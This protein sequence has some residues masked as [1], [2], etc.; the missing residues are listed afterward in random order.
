MANIKNLSAPDE[1]PYRVE[2]APYLDPPPTISRRALIGHAIAV[3]VYGVLA[4]LLVDHGAPLGKDILGL[5]SDPLLFIWCL[6]WW[7]HAVLQHLDPLHVRLLWQPGGI[8]LAWITSIPFLALLAAPVTLSFGPLVSYNLLAI[9]AP[10][11]A[12]CSAYLLCFYVSRRPVAAFCGGLVFGF[13]SYEMAESLE[14]LNLA[15]SALVPLLLLVV[16]CRLN[17]RLQRGSAA[18]LFALLLAGQFYISI[19]VAATSLFFGAL[20]WALASRLCPERRF[21]LQ[22]LVPDGIL[23]GAFAVPLLL[24][25]LWDMAFRPR[26]VLV[27][28]GWSIVTSTHL[29]NLLVTTPADVF[30]LPGF[31][32]GASGLLGL[33]PQ[34]DFSTGLPFLVLIILFLR[35][36][37]RTPRGKFL[38]IALLG[39][40]VASLGPQ[41][42]LGEKFTGVPMPWLVMSYVPLLNAALP[43]RFALYASLALALIL[44][45]WAGKSRWR[46]FLVGFA[47]LVTLAPLHPV[48]PAPISSFF[49]PG[50]VQAAL[51]PNARV[52]ILPAANKN[53]PGLWQVS[54]FLQAENKFGFVQ[55][56][57]YLGIPPK[58]MQRYA[59]IRELAFGLPAPHFAADVAILSAATHTQFILAGPDTPPALVEQLNTLP[60]PHRRVDDTLVYSVQN[61]AP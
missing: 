59:A 60:W 6:A 47:W 38:L 57:G 43:A 18:G 15:F 52:L 37:G 54:G 55:T 39:L 46:A 5:S 36:Q 2:N 40:L 19:E 34:S 12:A 21:V 22:R 3:L 20:A 4:V 26:Q 42:W 33:V 50:H 7:P 28:P 41:L 8:D 17:N 29:F 32:D 48:T 44:T 25:F 56:T 27:P 51:G 16:L 61:T 1:P 24:P 30:Y 53:S 35:E 23:A 11:L 31:R 58:S 45:F 13:S 10:C 9:A 14:H 49:Q